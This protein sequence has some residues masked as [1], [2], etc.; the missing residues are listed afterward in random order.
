[1]GI[2]WDYVNHTKRESVTLYLLREGGSKWGA[3]MTCA[4]ALMHLLARPSY[5]LEF[6]GRW[7]GDKIEIV[8]EAQQSSVYPEIDFHS[9]FLIRGYAKQ[10]HPQHYYTD[11]SHALLSELKS[12]YDSDWGDMFADWGTTRGEVVEPEDY[13]TVG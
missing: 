4:P 9:D 12:V 3:A 8:S 5:E 10:A 6:Q 11:I 7:S 2:T 13:V 1:M